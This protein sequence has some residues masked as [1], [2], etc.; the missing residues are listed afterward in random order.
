[1]MPMIDAT[2]F[3]FDDA[4][5][6]RAAQR[7]RFGY[8]RRSR[9]RLARLAQIAAFAVLLVIAAITADFLRFSFLVADHQS[10]PGVRAQGIVALTGGTARIDGALALLANDR[11]QRL[12]I[13]GVN[14]TVGKKEIATASEA[15]Y[16]PALDSRV[17]LGY[18]ARDTIGNA[19]EARDWAQDHAYRSLIVVTSDYHMP[20]SMAE[21]ESA[22]PDITLIPYPV[23]NPQLEMDHWWRHPGSVKLLLSEYLKYTLARA[24]LALGASREAR[25]SVPTETAAATAST[26]RVLR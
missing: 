24:R 23:T 16:P 11:A 22:M 6:A 2:R 8:R 17:D 5:S 14:P 19:D 10:P 4:P 12:L 20:R 15:N 9:S 13:S 21:L 3:Q 7:T 18:V 25:L 26:A 1:M